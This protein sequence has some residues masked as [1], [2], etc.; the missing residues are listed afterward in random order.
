[1]TPV[2]A[3]ILAAGKGT[4]MKSD[5]AKVIFELADKPLI[6][7]VVETAEEL[8]C[9]RICVVVGH[10]KESVMAALEGYPNLLFAVQEQQL[11][12][13]HAVMIAEESFSGYNGDIVI[14]AGD[15]PLLKADTLRKL[16]SVHQDSKAACTVLTAFLDDAGRYGRIIRNSQNKVVGIVE[17]KDASEAQLQIKEF[18]TGIWC[19][20][21]SALFDAIHKISNNNA[22]KEYYL[23]DT[24]EFLVQQGKTVEAMVLEDLQQAS[25]INSQQQLA[26]LEDALLEEIRMY[27]MNNGVL[28]HNPSTVHIGEDVIIEPDVTIEAHSTIKGKSRLEKGSQIGPNCHVDSA[29]IG[30]EAVLKGYN[31]VINAK[32]HDGEIIEWGEKI[33]E[34][35]LFQE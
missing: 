10:Q 28:I 14:L 5:K 23:T 21:A 19:F 22:Q 24:L 17:Y 7:R 15:V 30:R 3:I 25:G 33:L 26:E 2:A 35:T 6:R 11:G 4:R 9:D 18:N 27:W 1:M 8:N 13:G 20:N 16:I 31:V 32:V 29:D 12:T 34:E